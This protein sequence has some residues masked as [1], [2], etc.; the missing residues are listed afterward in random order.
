MLD[1]KKVSAEVLSQG[2]GKKVRII[3]FKRRKHHMKRMGHRQNF[4]ELKIT[5]IG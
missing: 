1:G 4:T 3:K 5:N 2:R